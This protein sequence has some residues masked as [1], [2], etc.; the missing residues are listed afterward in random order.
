[1]L[2]AKAK[3]VYF[4]QLTVNEGLS[5][6]EVRCVEAD[7]KGLIWI[8][9]QDGISVYNGISF[10][11]FKHN[12]FDTTTLSND[13]ILSIHCDKKGDMWVGTI[14]GLNVYDPITKKFARLISALGTGKIR[15]EQGVYVIQSDDKDRL[16]IGTGVGIVILNKK[17]FQPIAKIS[18]EATFDFTRQEIYD[19]CHVGQYA[20]VSTSTGLY[21]MSVEDNGKVHIEKISVNE[22]KELTITQVLKY[23]D[24]LLA[25]TS[26]GFYS[27]ENLTLKK[28]SCTNY[29]DKHLILIKA[30]SD[31]KNNLWASAD[32]RGLYRF[33]MQNDKLALL[34]SMT[35]TPYAPGGLKSSSIMCMYQ[36]K[37]GIIWLG[38]RDAGLFTYTLRKNYFTSWDNYLGN[39]SGIS[40]KSV[41]AICKHQYD[42]W[43]G[44]SNGLLYIN[45]KS[46][47]KKRY[48][49]K[50]GLLSNAVQ[51][52]YIDVNGK[53]WVGTTRGLCS[54]SGN[55]FVEEKLSTA[56]D[57][58]GVKNILHIAED[59]SKNLWVCTM[60]DMYYLSAQQQEWR[61]LS[62]NVKIASSPFY[63]VTN[64]FDDVRSNC[65][66]FTTG[67][68]L[69][70]IHKKDYS[71]T[72][73]DNN[74]KNRNSIISN[75]VLGIIHTRKNDTWLCTNKGLTKLTTTEK[76][77]M[78][79]NYTIADGL[80]NSVVY[81][82]YE[83]K[84]GK[85]WLSTNYGI[86][87]FDTEKQ[88]FVNYSKSD[89]LPIN[90]YNMGACYKDEKG[91]IYFGG[92]D[93]MVSF[94][95]SEQ[96]PNNITPE[97][98]V[99]SFKIFD[100][101]INIDSL[102]LTHKDV[103][104]HPNENHFTIQFQA[105]DYENALKCQYAYRLKGADDRWIN[106]GTINYISFT[107]LNVGK[108]TLEIKATN[109][110]G[111]WS[112]HI[113]AIPIKILPP[114]YKTYW[115]YGLLFFVIVIT[116]ALIY[117]YRLNRSIERLREDEKIRAEEHEKVRKLA[118][119]DFHDEFGNAITRIT[120]L[121]ELIRKKLNTPPL[122][123][124]DL[125]DKVADNSQRLY[126]GTKD[127][128]W[129]INPK[130]DNLFEVGI[131]LKDFGDDIFDK[132]ITTFNTEGINEYLCS[133]SF[134][135]GMARHIVYLFKEAMSNTLKH[136]EATSASLMVI[137]KEN[138]IIIQWTDGGKGFN[139]ELITKAGY[140]IDNMKSRADKV[141]GELA[142]TST[143]QGT[144]ISLVLYKEKLIYKT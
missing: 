114:F 96:E 85:L 68:G 100:N 56:K 58:V 55:K 121:T 3:V 69:V 126:Q 53:L 2:S 10:Q 75:Q 99:S 129:A 113:L 1:M 42:L 41:F 4:N 92:L 28:A 94:N 112:P 24:H 65:Y 57:R 103:V 77:N 48:T 67:N 35:E 40:G 13:Q 36:N 139:T 125:L 76:G 102:L 143:A 124:N 91:I 32:G 84:K 33:V 111:V 46:N 17:T 23:K 66:W 90:E 11:Y 15:R 106:I 127:F 49:I 144:T 43:V 89:G 39:E 101:K 52:V 82:G 123:I 93:G 135:M 104:I 142:I 20:Y 54:Y 120:I 134:P 133:Y 26:S 122:E 117:R 119:K 70:R 86:S 9:T 12:P 29:N 140:G 78:F 131:Q 132:T 130:N 61:S 47:T 8:G 45:L 19:I 31:D 79:V 59:N 21:R 6:S 18:K 98:I 118:A 83:D 16:W 97:I 22:T 136:A 73:Y 34:D 81:G 87:C 62:A 141:S 115:F 74:V 37:D 80:P 50:D 7:K 137:E 5:Q 72:Q 105:L 88:Q 71:L 51:A 109:A 64:M 63:F 44:T 128:I 27:V 107:N 60:N 25:S 110:S 116:I 95:P 14:Y 30:L 38:S 138:V 108:Y